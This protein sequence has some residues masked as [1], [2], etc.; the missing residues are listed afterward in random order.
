MCFP[1]E[2]YILLKDQDDGVRELKL[3]QENRVFNH[4]FTG[5][6]AL[7]LLVLQAYFYLLTASLLPYFCAGV[8]VVEW[9]IANGKAR[10][11]PEALMLATGLMNEGFL[12]PAGDLSKEGAESGEQSAFLD[13]TNALYYFVSSDEC[14][15]EEVYLVVNGY[16]VLYFLVIFQQDKL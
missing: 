12:Q 3:E 16:Y 6:V 10:N 8:T 4:C 2:L 15:K 5:T 7:V 9:L 1:S 13:H 11:R 14:P